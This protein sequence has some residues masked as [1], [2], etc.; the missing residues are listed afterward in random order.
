M[1]VG[2]FKKFF[3]NLQICMYYE[4]YKYSWVEIASNIQT[5][6]ANFLKFKITKPGTYYITIN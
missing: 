3:N 4:N 2:D 1:E 5:K 6:H